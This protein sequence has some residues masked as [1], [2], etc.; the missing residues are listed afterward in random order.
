MHLYPNSSN[1]VIT[2]TNSLLDRV[3]LTIHEYTQGEVRAYNNLFREGSAAYLQ[4]A[5]GSSWEWKDNLFDKYALNFYVSGT[6]IHSHNGYVT[7]YDRLTPTNA[8]DQVLTGS[9]AYEIGPLGRYYLPT[10]S[11]MIDTGSRNATNAGLYHYTTS[12]NQTKE[13]TSQVEIGFHYVAVN[14][15]GQPIDS[16]GDGLPDYFED[17]DGDGTV[18]SGETDWQSYN[19]LNSLTGTPGIQVFTPLK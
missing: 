11:I 18:D 5:L 10:N 1:I 7:G 19:S 2:L 12:T 17:L 8:N 6:F 16:D 14:S 9:P 3:N 13:L 15:S 4:V